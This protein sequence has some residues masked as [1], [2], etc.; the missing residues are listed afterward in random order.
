M[1]LLP[2]VYTV[3][4]CFYKFLNC[5][6]GCVVRASIKKKKKSQK[7]EQAVLPEALLTDG[8]PMITDMYGS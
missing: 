3:F 1:P 4:M 5:N 6:L 2:Y 8:A 7:D